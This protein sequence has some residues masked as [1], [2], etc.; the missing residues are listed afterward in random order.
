M[1]ERQP[2]FVV[3]DVNSDETAHCSNTILK[4]VVLTSAAGLIALGGAQAADLPV[5][6]KSIEYLKGCSA[7]GAGFYDIPGTDTCIKLGGFLRA[8]AMLGSNSFV[9]NPVSG[10]GAAHNRLS[11]AYTARSRADLS[12]DTRTASEYGV[13][14]TFFEGNFTWKT[15]STGAAGT[16]ATSYSGDGVGLGTLSIWYAFIQFAGFTVGKAVSQFS[17]P[18][19]NYPANNFFDGLPGGGGDAS[20]V[21][22]FSY[23]AD[24][25]QGI[26]AT[27]SAQDPTA[28]YQTNISNTTNA[29]AAGI[30]TGAYGSQSYGG[31]VAPDI[32]GMVRIDQAWGLFQASAGA[33]NNHAAYY[34]GSEATGHAADKW[35]WAGQ[36]ALSIK[37]IPTGAGD[38]INLQGAYTKGAS[39]FSIQENIPTGW[40]MYGGTRRTD[41]YQSIGFAGVSDAIYSGTT[42]ATG[43]A[44]Q[45]TTTYGFNAGYIHNWDPSWN[46]ALYGG[47]AAVRYTDAAKVQICGS[48]GMAALGLTGVCNPDFNIAAVGTVTRW[49]PVRNL[50]FSADLFATFLDQKYSGTITAPAVAAVAKPAAVYELKNQSAVSMLVRVQ[51]NW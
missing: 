48:A 1:T 23:T 50:T 34:G 35:G 40:A 45:L 7:Y 39:T 44:F 27:M 30:V 32:V 38:T 43:T 26:T 13:V 4:K 6:A 21:N 3:D 18:W 8:D 49:T 47:W 22:Q 17:A 31:T 41:V 5:K 2:S 20:G 9:L 51:R 29:T 28:Y 33:H 15:G 14:R 19:T 11:N 12:I 25:G 46:T 42:A 37:N 10:V 36:L 16:G 24:L